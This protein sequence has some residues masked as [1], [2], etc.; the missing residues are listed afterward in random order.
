MQ[1]N[2]VWTPRERMLAAY[3]GRF[4]DVVPVAPEFWY[5]VPARVLGM[6]MMDVER[7][8]PHW[9]ALQATFRHYGCEGWGC[10]EPGIPEGWGDIHRATQE[11]RINDERIEVRSTLRLGNHALQSR[12]L[13][14]VREPSWHLERYIKDFDRDW[15]IYAQA[16][17]IPPEDLDW[18]VVQSALDEVGDDYLLEISVGLP[19]V[20]YAGWQ[21]EGGFQ[22]VIIDLFERVDY[23]E[24]LQHRY[25][26]NISEKVRA[27][28]ACTTAR[29]VFVG[30]IWS[31]L[32]LLSPALWRKW[33]KPVLEAVVRAAHDSGGLVHHHFH[34]RCLRV[35]QEL[36]GIGLDCICPF[37]RPPGGDVV[38][39]A[40]VRTAL[41]GRTTFNGNVHTVETLIR[42]APADVEREVLQILEA[43]VGSP[44]LIVG[45]GDQ[46]GVETPDENI[47]AM[48][49]T[50]RKYGRS[51]GTSTSVVGGGSGRG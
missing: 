31:S 45:T 38:D 28:F 2:Q 5:Y 30:S 4:S 17:L 13:M 40:V 25:I 20:D 15:P 7:E 29:S 27:A 35:L 43:F 18:E 26:E 22:K 47:Y 48:I 23:L 50:V 8:V 12:T 44:R 37:E 41:G 14:D 33:D 21:R 24:E 3:E 46:V 39:L 34:G 49:E 51:F 11:T 19:F 32:S 1:K 10:V 9:Q 6:T 42:G 16:T 36:A